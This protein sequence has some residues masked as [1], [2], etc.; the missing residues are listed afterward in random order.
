MKKNFFEL[1]RAYSLSASMAPLL[2]AIGCAYNVSRLFESFEF[3]FNMSLI[4]FAVVILHLGCNLLDDF[5]DVK[6]ELKKGYS[7]DE[8]NFKNP[9]KARL[10][11]D[12]TYS[13]LDIKTILAT[14][15]F[16]AFLIGVYFA[17]LRGFPVI[18]LMFFTVFL[19]YIYPKSSTLGLQE[20]IISLIFGPMLINGVYF[21]LCGTFDS[22]VVLLSVASGLATSVLLLAHN[23]MDY[24]YDVYADKNTIPVML[25]DKNLAINFISLIITASYIPLLWIAARYNI[26]IFIVFPLILTLPSGLKL[27]LS[28][29]DYINIRDV[30]LT[31]H[32]YYGSMEGLE[33]AASNNMQHFMYRFYLARNFAAIFNLSLALVCFFF[34]APMDVFNINNIRFIINHFM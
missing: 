17:V 27:V 11:L 30:E 26:L 19:A 22:K 34:Y 5:I 3:V 9:M 24:E 21:A 31:K 33:E 2:I 28:L 13:F 32:W 7:P 29:Y 20:L 6:S 23:L 15:F 1:T 12:G 10:I 8:I 16:I 25:K 18:L 4:I 14:I